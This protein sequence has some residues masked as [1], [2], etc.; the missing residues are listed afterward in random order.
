MSTFAA[1]M[2][3]KG[4]GPIA[5]IE[6]FGD[7]ADG[8]VK[9]IFTPAT[10][11]PGKILIGTITN[12]SDVID[13]VTI[14]C[15]RPETIAIHCHGNPL[16]VAEI[17]RLLKQHGAKPITA[18]KLRAKILSQ[19]QNINT[20]ALEA[21]LAQTKA[22]TIQG[23]KIILNQ[24]DAGLNAKA[25]K[26]LS[27]IN[28]KS[29]EEIR[30]QADSILRDSEKA[31]L[32]IAGCSIVLIGPPNTGKSTLLN[33]LSGRQKAIVTDIKGTTRDWVGARC[34]I[35]PLSAE[36]I[37]TA[38]LDVRPEDTIETT[39][40]QKSIQLLE[41]TDLLLFVLDNSESFDQL[42]RKLAEKIL[43]KKVLTVLNKSDLPAVFDADK[44]PKHLSDTVK[45]SAKFGTAIE[46]LLEKIQNVL[47]VTDFD[48]HSPVCITSRQR[49]LVQKLCTVKSTKQAVSIITEL[50]SGGV[51]V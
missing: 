44:L 32:I 31:K 5:T 33:F 50:L 40:Q 37:D 47:G 1:V 9:K 20:I 39:A 8:I 11:T 14:G 36:L 4:A 3:G 51:C 16:I 45:I 6:V 21:K 23:T 18:D 35:G 46:E 49:E 28:T 38:G 42:D 27:G 29:I 2:T 15:E 26:W 25:Q 30:T 41:Q 43:G 48:L 12:G 13:Q 19:E 22:K 17:M 10:F 34:Q 7:K 24:I